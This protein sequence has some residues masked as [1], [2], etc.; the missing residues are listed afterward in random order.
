[1]LDIDAH[2]VERVR[3]GEAEAFDRLT[4]RHMDAAYAVALAILGAPADAEDAVQD[5]FV[6]ALQRIDQCREPAKFRAWLLQIVRNRVHSAL[7]TPHARRA[8]ALDEALPL[9][10]ASDPA[11]DAERADLRGH[12]ATA[13]RALSPLQREVVVLFDM[14]GWSH[15]EIAAQAG[16]TEAASRV[17]LFKARA[18]LRRLLG[19]HFTRRD[20]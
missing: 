17:A 1:M 18:A 16:T 4:D 7:R 10:S 19:P 6:L 11:R 3:R 12:L 20:G 2:L 15:R 13:L 14:E 5:A 8:V 9:P